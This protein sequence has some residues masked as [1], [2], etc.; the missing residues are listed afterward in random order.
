MGRRGRILGTVAVALVA[1]GLA[2]P[3][4]ADP[5]PPFDLDP[6]KL[7]ARMDACMAHAVGEQE[8]LMG[9]VSLR[10]GR[11]RQWRCSSLR[12]MFWDDEDRERRDPFV[13]VAAFMRGTDKVVSYG[14][15][16]PGKGAGNT[17]LHYQYNGT[18]GHAYAIV[19]DDTGDIVSIYV[20]PDNDWI[21][22]ANGL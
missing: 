13:D 4:A 5:I 16:R 8:V 6:V 14:F 3:A 12:H 9:W 17:N 22:C 21:G 15:P 1:V 18:R 11:H 10:D 7:E 19:N 20:N 2:T